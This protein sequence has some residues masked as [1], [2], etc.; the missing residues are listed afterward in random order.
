MIMFTKNLLAVLLLIITITA[1]AQKNFSYKPENPKP[2][3]II[4]FTYEPAGDIANTILPV[5]G[6][7]YQNGAKG[8]KADDIVLEKLAGKYS[9]SIIADTGMNFIYFGF[10]ADKKF[11][12]NFNEGYTILLYQNDKPRNGA[13][14]NLSSF[15][16]GSGRQVGL[17]SSNEKALAAMEKEF[18]LFP[19]N[20]KINLYGYTRLQTLL[21]KE[22]ASKIIQKEIEG[23]L[24]AGIKEEADYTTIGNLYML[25][26]LPEQQKL[27][28]GLK[29]EKFPGGNWQVSESFQKF[30]QEK[31]MEK[32]KQMLP[33]ILNKIETL[34]KWKIYKQNLDNIKAQMAYAYMEKKDWVNFKQALADSKIED[35]NQLAGLYNSAAW[36][37]QKTNEN[38]DLAEYFSSLATAYAKEE[39][40]KPTGKKPD[41]YTQKQ[42]VE[43]NKNSYASYASTYGLVLYRKGEY[44]KG[45]PYA[46][47]AAMLISKGKDADQNS[48]YAMLA[49]KVLP[50][51]Q[52]VKELEQFV[53]DGKSS[54]EIK[55]ILKRVYVNDKKDE[56]GFE[57]YITVLQK[58]SYLKMLEELRKTM[59]NEK[60]P[61]F[62]LV[63]LEGKKVNLVDLKDKVVI[64]DF[65]ATWCGPC[66]ASFPGMQKMV[67]KYKDDPNVKFVFIDTWERG[68]AKE[69]NAAEF[70][71]TNKYSFNVLMDNED[72]VVAEFKVDGIPTKFVIDKKGNI[73]FKAIG[74]DGSDD[75]LINELSAMIDMTSKGG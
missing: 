65:W 23:M 69:K 34:E 63:D 5:E 53:K 55:E 49:E 16:Q 31:D 20:R 13:Y 14:K 45:L 57:D 21:N 19:E 33:D 67:T 71:A 68:E 75:K 26:K 15:Y 44:K 50:K 39:Q 48:A 51:K 60:A 9:G 64:V 42:W 61:V 18:A 46:K 41:Y 40:L 22:N 4:T 66:K 10:T 62:T 2:G 25:A 36:E 3:D 58:E 56:T 37:I 35:K 12:N 24:K 38:L 43:D 54:A 74:F 32:K 27:M 72:K 28:E 59:M 29:K 6:I 73:R 70:I 8:M 1:Q 52:Y 30:Y 7:V 47:E 17:E 11:D